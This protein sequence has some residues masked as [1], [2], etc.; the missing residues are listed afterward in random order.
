MMRFFRGR[1]LFA[2]AVALV[3]LS[4]AGIA[5][6]TG[7]GFAGSDGVIQA[8]AKNDNGA[9]RVLGLETQSSEL[10]ACKDN[11][12]AI[13]WNQT[14][15]GG[16]GLSGYQV[17]AATSPAVDF[18]HDAVAT[19]TCPAGMLPVGGGL[20]DST[21]GTTPAR[22]TIE[23]SYPSGPGWTVQAHNINFPSPGSNTFMVYA[24][25]VTAS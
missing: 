10:R 9:L 16:D 14:G 13:S 17:V 2:P 19:A 18:T 22:W 6:A 4:A 3:S 24:V 21:P 8:C 25:C 11:E 12:T 5:F 7:A 20:S 15:S 1:A 23:E